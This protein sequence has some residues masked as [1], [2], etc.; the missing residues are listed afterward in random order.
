M[1]Y[2]DSTFRAFRSSTLCCLLGLNLLVGAAVG[3]P[4]EVRFLT[5]QSAVGTDQAWGSFSTPF[6][7][8]R[9]NVAFAGGFSSSIV[10]GVWTDAGGPRLVARFGDDAPGITPNMPFRL[11]SFRSVVLAETG[12]VGFTAVVPIDGDPRFREGAWMETSDPPGSGSLSLLAVGNGPAPAAGPTAV[13]SRVGSP[14]FLAP[15]K[16]LFWASS[17]ESESASQSR[18]GV[19]LADADRPGQLIRV[20]GERDPALTFAEDGEWINFWGWKAN[21]LGQ[22]A[23][24]MTALSKTLDLKVRGLWTSDP[25]GSTTLIPRVLD[26]DSAPGFEPGHYFSNIRPAT[27]HNDRGQIAFGATRNTAPTSSRDNRPR[28]GIWVSEPDGSIRLVEEGSATDFSMNDHGEVAYWRAGSIKTEAYGR[29]GQAE[30]LAVEGGPVPS[31][32]PFVT[33]SRLSIPTINNARQTAFNSVFRGRGITKEND[34]A[35]WATDL[36]GL[37]QLVVREGDEIDLSD[38]P[39]NPD[40]RTLESWTWSNFNDAGELPFKARFTDGS[41]AIVIAKTLATAATLRGDFDGSGRVDQTDLD[42]VLSSWG[43]LRFF[44]S[45]LPWRNTEGLS[46]SIVDQ[47]ELNRVLSN[48]GHSVEPD[49]DALVIAEVPEPIWGFVLPTAVAIAFRKR[50][51]G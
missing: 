1:V 29:F 3:A 7:N 45:G 41:E 51:T 32:G 14:R 11:G 6:I 40:L 37:L 24:V 20:V 19:Y 44:T 26:G 35:L 10:S 47:E 46:T 5:G 4:L 21:G 27:V 31:L 38:D 9:G 23:Y 33:F 42:H 36:N 2:D 48:W 39:D 49:K 13:F 43:K 50:L 17:R 16:A 30:R 22:V 18:G 15:G 25:D 28:S 12:H 8:G 34:R